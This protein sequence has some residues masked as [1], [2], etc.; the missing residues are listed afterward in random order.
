MTIKY[1]IPLRRRD[2]SVRVHAVVDHDDWLWA[3]QFRWSLGGA[4]YA[5]RT[6]QGGGARQGQQRPKTIVQALHRAIAERMGIGDA[7]MID[8]RNRDP[9]DCRRSNL[10]PA[11]PVLNARNRPKGSGPAPQHFGCTEPD[12]GEKHYARGKCRR[13]WFRDYQRERRAAA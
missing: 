8:H 11:D 13:H 4:G 7:P 1:L 2:G 3:S 10:R 6:V 9:L 12:C 5:Q